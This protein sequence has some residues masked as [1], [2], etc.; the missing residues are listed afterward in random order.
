MDGRG[1]GLRRGVSRCGRCCRATKAE[2]IKREDIPRAVVLALAGRPTSR[3]SCFGRNA[4]A[5]AALSPSLSLPHR[6]EP[7]L[8]HRVAPLQLSCG[9]GRSFPSSSSL[10]FS[11]HPFLS[12]LFSSHLPLIFSAAAGCSAYSRQVTQLQP[13]LFLSLSAF[14]ATR[15]SCLGLS[16]SPLSSRDSESATGYRRRS[17]AMHLSFLF[18]SR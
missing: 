15:V 5:A 3:P 2:R 4:P 9:L 14:R 13:S 18:S 10:L 16:T 11:A 1:C 17:A 6:A 12:S 7:R 8:M